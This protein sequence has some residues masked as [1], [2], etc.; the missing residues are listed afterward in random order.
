MKVK[1]TKT[2]VNELNKVKKQYPKFKDYEIEFCEMDENTYRWYVDLDAWW[3]EC[4]DFNLKTGKFN[5]IRVIYPPDYCACNKFITTKDLNKIY[6]RSDKTYAGF[7][8]DVLEE[9]EA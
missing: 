7:F 4:D 2:F 1:V 8:A 6:L 9:I 3:T 5:A